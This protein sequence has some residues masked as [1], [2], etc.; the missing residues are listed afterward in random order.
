MQKQ[1]RYKTILV[2]VSGFLVIAWVLFVKDFTNAAQILAKVAIG[3]G[4]VSVFIPIAAKGIEWVW[5]KIAHILGWIN[6]KILLG[7]IFF[8]FLL[9]IAWLSRLFTKDPLK[10]N[11]R[12]LKSLYNDRNHLYTKEDLEN[13]W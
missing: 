1:D 10:L 11:G 8:I 3:I 12:Q 5:L 9:P 4:L 7:L 6:S 2:I 13:I